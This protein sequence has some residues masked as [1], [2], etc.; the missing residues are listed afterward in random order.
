MILKALLLVYL[1]QCVT[2]KHSK[3]RLYRSCNGD[4]DEKL[5]ND[6]R[7]FVWLSSSTEETEYSALTC[8]QFGLSYIC[9][10]TVNCDVETVGCSDVV[11][12]AAPK[13]RPLLPSTPANFLQVVSYNVLELDYEYSVPIFNIPPSYQYTGQRE[14]T[15]R[16]PLEILKNIRRVDVIVFQE[17]AMGGCFPGK[18][19]FRDLL[20]YY[21]FK[22]VTP[23][24]GIA[25]EA[26]NFLIFENGGTFI[27]SRWPIAYYEDYIF[28]NTD[29]TT[30]DPFS[31][32]GIM[33]AHVMK[34]VHNRTLPYHVFGTHMQA[35]VGDSRQAIRELQATEFE[36]F[37]SRRNI[38][39]TEAVI[40]AGDFNAD[41]NNFQDHAERVLENM[42]AILP[43]R[44]GRV[45][46][47]FDPLTN[48]LNRLVNEPQEQWIDYVVLSSAHKSNA[49][50]LLSV[51]KPKT[52]PLNI[53]VNATTGG[54]VSATSPDCLGS[55]VI[56]DLS[57]H[58][59]LVG[60]FYFPDPPKKGHKKRKNSY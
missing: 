25:E 15:C 52:K 41:L 14:R 31:S 3:G 12:C 53:C 22:Y 24:V 37:I 51:F 42:G 48:D 16:I 40:M 1:I 19:D 32:K 4:E 49:K 33:Y 2:S 11:I 8:K 47:T 20:K 38:P 50:S 28:N 10:S 45:R 27:A 35:Q 57:D 30:F 26:E 29:P 6:E 44:V 5:T 21:G 36:N 23:N 60:R 34:T 7:P 17:L 59:G 13:A 55:L 18:L 58:F 9:T 46:T 56:T 43:R 54:Y 39:S